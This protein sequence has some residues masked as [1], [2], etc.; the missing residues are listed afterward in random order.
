MPR[1]YIRTMG[2]NLAK[3]IEEHALLSFFLGVRLSQWTTLTP[4]GYCRLPCCTRDQSPSRPLRDTSNMALA[5]YV[6]TLSERSV[7]VGGTFLLMNDC[8]ASVVTCSSTPS[9]GNYPG[10]CPSGTYCDG[11]GGGGYCCPSS[12]YL[13]DGRRGVGCCSHSY[14]Q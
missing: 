13:I 2:S 11:N 12:K 7:F 4:F 5:E 14:S 8:P 9:W 1:N 3:R 10:C 6:S